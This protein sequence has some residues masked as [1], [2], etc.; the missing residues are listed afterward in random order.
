MNVYLFNFEL[1]FFS[2]TISSLILGIFAYY[3]NRTSAI[4]QIFCLFCM[5]ISIWGF[6]QMQLGIVPDI[7]IALILAKI[8]HAHKANKPVD[9]HAP[10]V[11]GE[12]L[13]KYVSHGISTEHE[14]S[15][16]EEAREKVKAGL[17]IIIR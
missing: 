1:S 17:K 14:C 7:S 16:L 3:K 6:F 12:A 13:K 8:E 15:D 11:L 9:G 4:N 2:I 10:M 5:S